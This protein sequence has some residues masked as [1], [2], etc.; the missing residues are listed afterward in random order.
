MVNLKEF[1]LALRLY[2]DE[3]AGRYPSPE[4]W[5]DV[6]ADQYHQKTGKRAAQFRRSY[7]CPAVPKDGWGYAMNPLASPKSDPNVVLVFE[8]DAGWN[9]C[10]GPE[11]LVIGRHRGGGCNI[12]FVNGDIMFVRTE[13][14]AE[15][16]WKDQGT[17]VPE[18]KDD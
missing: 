2:A 11:S 6:L 5:C 18:K 7:R 12:T 4:R 9:G 16:K 1:G 17:F 15:L 10:G 13:R 8:S 3:H 14:L